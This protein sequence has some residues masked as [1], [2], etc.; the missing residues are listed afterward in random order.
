MFQVLK[1]IKRKK[2]PSLPLQ[3]ILGLSSDPRLG[4]S[5]KARLRTT[6]KSCERKFKKKIIRFISSLFRDLFFNVNCSQTLGV[7]FDCPGT[8]AAPPIFPLMWFQSRFSVLPLLY[9]LLNFVCM[10]NLIKPISLT[11][12]LNEWSASHL[13]TGDASGCASTQER[14]LPQDLGWQ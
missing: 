10:Y 8:E 14:N 11:L 13:P 3:S 5:S 1:C 6:K 7:H 12:S 2:R 9:P 4:A